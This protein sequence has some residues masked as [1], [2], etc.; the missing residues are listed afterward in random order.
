M[1]ICGN[2][3]YLEDCNGSYECPF[4]E[5]DDYDEY[6]E[7]L[8]IQ[9]MQQEGLYMKLIVYNNKM[10]DIV[11]IGLYDENNKWIKWISKKLLDKYI[12]EVEEVENQII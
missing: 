6:D 7:Q 3:P 8:T 9:K 4:W 10:G 1:I 11:R 12:D 2:C 5:D